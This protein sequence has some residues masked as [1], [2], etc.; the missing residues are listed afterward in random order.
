MNP[1]N[2]ELNVQP[3]SHF[4]TE[5]WWAHLGLNQGPLAC[6][7]SALPLSYAPILQYRSKLNLSSRNSDDL[8]IKNIAQTTGILLELKAK[9]RSFEQLN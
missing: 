7:A 9:K 8:G 1:K 2:P 5:S 4:L 3:L 6:Q